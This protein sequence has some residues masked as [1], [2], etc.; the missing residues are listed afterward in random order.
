MAFVPSKIGQHKRLSGLAPK[1]TK[2]SRPGA[3][4]LLSIQYRPHGD[5]GLV[6]EVKVVKVVVAQTAGNSSV[7]V[8]KALKPEPDSPG[9]DAL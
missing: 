6:N 8:I 3:E 2:N 9:G 4:G 1:M 5:R 7:P